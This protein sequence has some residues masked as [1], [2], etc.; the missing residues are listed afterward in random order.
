MLNESPRDQNTF[1]PL[2]RYVLVPMFSM[3]AKMSFWAPSGP[4]L[5][6]QLR[7]I[8]AIAS[9]QIVFFIL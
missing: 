9:K 4:W 1:V 8:I 5:R 2:A 3:V 6:L 7:V